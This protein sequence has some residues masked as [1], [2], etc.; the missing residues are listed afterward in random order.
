[1]KQGPAGKGRALQILSGLSLPSLCTEPGIN[2]FLCLVLGKAITLL[3]FAFE[4]FPLTVDRC[5]VIVREFAPLSFDFALKLFPVSFN[6]V[7]VHGDLHTSL[8][9]GHSLSGLLVAAKPL[10][11]GTRGA[12]LCP[13][14]SRTLK[15]PRAGNRL[16]A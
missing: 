10:V 6:A 7:P 14:A 3:E 4:L 11:G 1:M 12:R 15:P 13:L 9:G 8:R 5:K 16:S 2:L